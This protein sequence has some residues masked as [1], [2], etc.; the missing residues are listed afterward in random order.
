MDK[1]R[2]QYI[3]KAAQTEQ[4]HNLPLILR[5]FIQFVGNQESPPSPEYNRYSPS[6][7]PEARVSTSPKQQQTQKE[8]EN[9]HEEDQ[10]RR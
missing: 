2:N 5:D 7:A 1:H 4:D 10:E 9:V 3:E 6:K 8:V